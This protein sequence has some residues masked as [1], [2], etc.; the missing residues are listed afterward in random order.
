MRETPIA[1]LCRGRLNPERTIAAL[2][3]AI[4]VLGLGACTQTDR[5]E[6]D[7]PGTRERSEAALSRRAGPID[8]ARAIAIARDYL[9]RRTGHSQEDTDVEARGNRSGWSVQ[10][11]RHPA[12][13][14]GHSTVVISAEGNVEYVIPGE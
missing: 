9:G 12:V 11:S 5:G 7:A 6:S 4:L 8:K 1:Q 13:P 14:G 2:L 3:G 10:V